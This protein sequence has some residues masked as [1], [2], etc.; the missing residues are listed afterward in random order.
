MPAYNFKERFAADVET[1]SKRQTIRHT[2]KRPT[3]PGDTLYL[4]VGMRTK[5]CR[6]LREAICESVVPILI[7]GLYNITLYPEDNERRRALSGPEIDQLA[8][9]DGFASAAE[10]VG[11]FWKELPFKGEIIRWEGGRD[12]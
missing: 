12:E 9:D 5:R 8:Q 11:F 7:M 3:K 10:F 4:Y 2:R 1:G 6:K